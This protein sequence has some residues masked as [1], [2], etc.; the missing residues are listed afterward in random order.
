MKTTLST[1]TEA[2]PIRGA[3]TLSRGSKTEAVV[4][5]CRIARDGV[6]GTGECVPYARY[7]ETVESVLAQIDEV[8]PLV[9]DGAGR[10]EINAAMAPGAARNAVDCALWDLEAKQSGLP[11]HRRICAAPPRPVPTCVTISLD[12]PQEMAQHARANAMRPMLKVKL[13]GSNDEDIIHAVTAA[14][15]DARII[16]DA[17]ESWTP[18]NIHDLMMVAAQARIMLIEQPLPAGQDEIL[19][20]IPHP[21]PICADESVHVTAD[22]EPMRERYDAVNIKLDKTGGLTEALAMRMRAHEI[23]YSVMVGC[24]VATSLSMAPAILLA[25]EAQYVDLDGPLLLTRDRLHGLHYSAV[26]VSPPDP[27]LWG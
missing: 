2:W 6:T 11:V 8:T 16:L 1:E 15:P 26:V 14:A 23:G 17:N 25:Q 9:A 12:D 3:F 7:G 20:H 22:L 19:E 27:R 21:V 10:K 4:V 13:G 24:M 18:D 5:V